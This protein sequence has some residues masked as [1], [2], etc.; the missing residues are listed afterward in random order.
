MLRLLAAVALAL[1]ATAAPAAPAASPVAAPSKHIA[2]VMARGDGRSAET[3]YRVGS[4]REEYEI[5]RALGLQVE[6]QA[7]V[8]ARKKPYDV[9]TVRERGGGTRAL[10][11]DIGSFFPEF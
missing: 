1:V 5:V 8:Q 4:V 7:L 3:A 6:S 11:F 9:L 2:K 10:W